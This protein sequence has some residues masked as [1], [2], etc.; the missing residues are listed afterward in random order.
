MRL[1][2]CLLG[3]DIIRRC[4]L[5]GVGVGFLEE[6]QLRVSFE[7]SNAQARSSLTLPAA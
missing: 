1:N 2:A 4:G 6:V 7:V 3:S 5:A